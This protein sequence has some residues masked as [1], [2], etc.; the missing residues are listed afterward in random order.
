MLGARVPM[1]ADDEGTA[2]GLAS[3]PR[4]AAQVSPAPSSA[5]KCVAERAGTSEAKA[6]CVSSRHLPRGQLDGES[7]GRRWLAPTK[8]PPTARACSSSLR[9][10]GILGPRLPVSG[11]V[12]AA[13]R[14][15]DGGNAARPTPIA[16]AKRTGLRHDMDKPAGDS[17]EAPPK[18]GKLSGPLPLGE[19]KSGLAPRE[20]ARPEG[21][22]GEEGR[23]GALEP[24]EAPR[25]RGGAPAATGHAAGSSRADG[26]RRH[27][28][29]RAAPLREAQHASGTPPPQPRLEQGGDCRRAQAMLRPP[30]PPGSAPGREQHRSSCCEVPRLAERE[31][32]PV[33]REE[34][35]GLRMP[36]EGDPC[37][38]GSGGRWL[39]DDRKGRP[40]PRR[41]HHALRAQSAPAASRLRGVPA[42]AGRARPPTKRRGSRRSPASLRKRRRRPAGRAA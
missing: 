13:R 14:P 38:A 1:R 42:R 9:R 10:G 29:Q 33:R 11:S 36:E 24:M 3:R 27:V 5:R 17:I 12:P 28:R 15:V 35:E 8:S 19:G 40:R 41:L 30:R 4:P 37:A 23:A 20:E 7:P 16:S 18:A 31:Q 21:A 6:R 26:L 22:R 32:L 39:A 25:S 34:A 2:D